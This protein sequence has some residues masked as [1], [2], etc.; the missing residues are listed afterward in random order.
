MLLKRI[1]KIVLQILHSCILIDHL[2]RD[3][4]GLVLSSSSSSC[5]AE[6]TKRRGALGLRLIINLKIPGL[7]K[8]PE[9]NFMISLRLAIIA[10]T[11]VA[12]TLNLPGNDVG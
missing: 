11:H 3:P 4:T 6:K 8:F 12:P 10:N 5:F 9:F 7:L 2:S 1:Y